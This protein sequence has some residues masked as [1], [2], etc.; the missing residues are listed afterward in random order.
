MDGAEQD[1][2]EQRGEVAER[3]VGAAGD[4]QGVT[5]SGHNRPAV[6]LSRSQRG[7]L[8]LPQHL[9]TTLCLQLQVKFTECLTRRV[10][11]LPSGER[12]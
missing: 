9:N 7:A 12:R 5:S 6:T 1:V 3:L 10:S 8:L 2:C 11:L 4:D